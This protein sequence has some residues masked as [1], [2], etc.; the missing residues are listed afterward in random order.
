MYI[1]NMRIGCVWGH[2]LY[3]NIYVTWHLG[4][5][6]LPRDSI[7]CLWWMIY[8]LFAGRIFTVLSEFLFCAVNDDSNKTILEFDNKNMLCKPDCFMLYFNKFWG[9]PLVIRNMSWYLWYWKTMYFQFSS[10]VLMIIDLHRNRLIAYYCL[11]IKRFDL[12]Y[13]WEN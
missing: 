13:Y 6:R 7:V 4:Q 12:I 2:R 3:N 5:I 9:P 10:G 11:L 1:L 8:V